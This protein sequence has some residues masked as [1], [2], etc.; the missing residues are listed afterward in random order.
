MV[1]AYKNGI[2]IVGRAIT[3]ERKLGAIE[4]NTIFFSHFG[5]IYN[6]L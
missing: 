3:T 5:G 1:V 2:T 6:L 4:K